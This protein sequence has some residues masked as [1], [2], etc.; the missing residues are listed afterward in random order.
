MKNHARGLTADTAMFLAAFMPAV[1][2]AQSAAPAGEADTDSSGG[3][4]DII[5]TASKR[6]ENLQKAPSAVSVVGGDRIADSGLVDATQLSKIVPGLVI[7]RQGANAVLFLRGVGQTS[8]TPA[9]QPGI[10]LNIDGVYVPRELGG[11]T[12]FDLERVEVL[13]GPQGTLYGRNSAGGAINLVTRK[14]GREFA[15]EGFAEVGNYGLVHTFGAVDV[16][17]AESLAVRAAVDVN[18]RDGYLSNGANDA[19]SLSG[20]ISALYEPGSGV[21]ALL[22]YTYLRQGG[23]GM[24]YMAKGGDKGPPF[25]ST[26]DPWFN[27]FPN[28]DLSYRYRGHIVTGN[29]G[30]DLSDN[31]TL[32]YIANYSQAKLEHRLQFFGTLHNRYP[33]SLKQYSQELRLANDGTG[34]LKWLAGL[35]WYKAESLADVNLSIPGGPPIVFVHFGNKLDSWAAFGQATYSISDAFRLTVGGRYSSDKFDGEGSQ[36]AVFPPPAVSQTYAAALRKGRADWKIGV[37][38]DAAPQSMLYLTAQSGY[39]QGGFTQVDIRSTLPKTF[40]PVKLIAFTGGAKNRFLDNRLQINNEIFYYIYSDYQTQTVGIDQNTNLTAFLIRNAPK[41]V[42][43]GNQLDVT[44]NATDNTDLNVSVA[45]LHS[46]I[47][48][49]F[50]PPSTPAPAGFN[51]F[52]GYE[53]VNAPKWTINGAIE[54]RFPLGNG[55]KITARVSST[56]NSGYWTVFTQEA[57][58]RQKSFTKTDANLTYYAPEERWYLG[59][60]IRNMENT[61]T[62]FGTGQPS[63]DGSFVPTFIDAPRTYG[64]R[65]GFNF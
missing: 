19:D 15:A 41:T 16:P 10:S 62:Y 20:R 52:K 39:L 22:Q 50:S 11:A 17:V 31:I 38:Y 9:A 51:S 49:G 37:E 54:Q 43:Y 57:Y 60:W 58:T 55:G 63:F 45:Y 12:M 28:D 47:T 35:F 53:M 25:G 33:Q 56:Y 6:S 2:L 32:N 42:I 8:S 23:V 1:A 24:A 3:L 27:S 30:I 4:A 65:A 64:L 59:A 61:A 26:S 44:Y 29:V 18:M 14:P 46:E 21:S 40:D 48:K 34:R 13:P 5:V 36:V 7:G